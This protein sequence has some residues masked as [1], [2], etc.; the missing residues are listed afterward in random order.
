MLNAKEFFF[1][2]SFRSKVG[3]KRYL[4]LVTQQNN[5]Q[6]FGNVRHKHPKKTTPGVRETVEKCLS[7]RVP[8]ELSCEKALHLGDIV[9]S[10]AQHRHE[11]ARQVDG[12]SFFSQRYFTQCTRAK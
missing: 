6:L 3:A 2:F 7:G 1:F 12:A 10:Q 11:E 8:L 9:R 5:L 4:C